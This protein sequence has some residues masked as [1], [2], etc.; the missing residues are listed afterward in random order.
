MN[1]PLIFKRMLGDSETARAILLHDWSATGL[2]PMNGWSP[3][4]RSAVRMVCRA[5]AS[6]ALLWGPEGLL[7]YNQGYREIV[8]ERHPAAL[9]ASAFSVW[10]EAESFNRDVVRRV[11]EGESVSLRDVEFLLQRDGEQRPAWFDLDYSPLLDDQGIVLGALALVVEKTRTILAVKQLEQERA[12]F[13]DLF[14]QAPTFMAL[15][16]GPQ[17]VFDRVNPGYA[18]L[19]GHRD[20]VGKTVAQAL[21]E[22]VEQGF[23]DLLDRVFQ[24]GVAF[25]G[26]A[27][28]F[29]VQSVPGGR[30]DLRYLDFVYQPIRDF[31]GAV[32]SIFVEGVD[33]TERELISAEIRR[34][35]V[36]N[37][38]ILDSAIDYAIV[39]F[40][41][42]GKVTQWNQGAFRVLGWSEQEML[43]Q[44]GSRFFTP[45]DRAADRMRTEM[46]CALESG[47][48]ND[49][50]WHLRKS[51][52]RFWAS[53]EMTPLLDEQ[54]R[55]VGFVKVL[56]D[57]TERHRA[58]KAL[59]D[60]VR[61]L[62]VAQEIGALGT[63]T[64]DLESGE[65]QGTRGFFRIFGLPGQERIDAAAIE[66]LVVPDDALVRSSAS[67]RLDQSAP[68]D[69]Q[70]RIRRADDG[71]ERWIARQAEFERDA[72]GLPVRMVGVVQDITERKAQEMAV[73]ESSAQFKTLAQALPNQVWTTSA[74]GK[75]DWIN[76]RLTDYIGADRIVG[77]TQSWLDFLHADDLANTRML[78]E[79]SVATG[80]PYETE[81]RLQR[82]DG[83]YRWHLSR[84]L[85]L[86]T[87]DGA[88][89]RWIGTSTDIHANK[90]LE[91]QTKRDRNR[92]WTLS[93]ELMLIYTFEG[94]IAA[95]N[96]SATRLLGWSE[97]DM[98]GR[99][100]SD[101]LHADDIAASA[102]EVDKLNHGIT[103]LA[104][105]NRYRGKDGAFRV[106]DWT[107]VPD[108]GMIHAIGR[109]VT[110]ERATEAAL[111]Q[112]Q[113]L[114]AIGQLTG[115]VA[116]DFNNVLAVIRTAVDM[117]RLVKLTEERRVRYVTA[118]SDAVTRA[119]KLTAQLL[120]FARR[121]ALQPVVFDVNRNI[122]QVSAMVGSL[123]GARV[124]MTV[125][126]AATP[127]FVDADPNQF[128]TAIVN[129]A[130]N[131]RDA[132]NGN[133]R[134]T[135]AVRP[136]AEI[137]AVLG[138]D[139]VA[140]RFVA[141]SVAD[142]G[143]GIS[144]DN[145]VQIFEP[146][147]TTK[148]VGH[149]TGLGLSQVFGFAK[150]SGG[151]ITV[152]S[153]P[154]AGATFTLFLPRSTQ[155][156]APDAESPLTRIARG[157]GGCVLVVEDNPE[158]A[159]SVEMTLEELG[160][161]TVVALS[162]EQALQIL[163]NDATGFA[164]VFSDVVLGG[165][166]GIE[167]GNHVR[168]LYP[169]LP[170]VLSSGYSYVLATNPDH[171]FTLLPKPYALA[172]LA[173][174]LSDAI[175]GRVAAAPAPLA[176][177]A[178]QSLAAHHNVND[179]DAELFRQAELDSLQIL[180]TGD[181]AVFD[182]ITRMAAEYCGVP[183][184]LISL[185]DADRQW[186]K[187]RVGLQAQ[188]TPREYAFCD[189]A[190]RVPNETLIVHDATA[191]VRF[192]DNPLVTG[193][194][195]IRFYAGAPLVTSNGKAIGTLC[196]IDSVARTLDAGQIEMLNLL[197]K[198]VIYLLE[199]RRSKK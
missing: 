104:F 169:A 133:G 190:I 154:G 119:T 94:K 139:A 127:C 61:R 140:G 108:G 45:E 79:R 32:T 106:F 113:K 132:M 5:P 23:V 125:D 193:D 100:L 178:E 160:Y 87:P 117:M 17:H 142:T 89:S 70:Y 199:E 166:N 88:I 111:R 1:A 63:Y 162:A 110:R 134:L 15:L 170:I 68:L 20:V 177:A 128:D 24:T 122:Q 129:L 31:N 130:V 116:H 146:F 107:A 147:F 64:V 189:H 156:S 120:A 186:F 137:P 48:G 165:M 65:L 38:Q 62:D 150:Q 109:D 2:G 187:S 145:L 9:G 6:M 81:F 66:A 26:N 103:T 10:P 50:R 153:E 148:G 164:V 82:H 181:E 182:E 115:G 77:G 76:R 75:L 151:E 143:F 21:P 98:V 172:E 179:G 96:P 58:A 198:R 92:I 11:G 59:D 95:V 42:D 27:V 163:A 105:E 39:A 184:A 188:Q 192:A 196:V 67:S 37:R 123:T 4:L 118:I 53:G 93:Q 157:N 174:T 22:A 168:R 84:A 114:E 83:Q 30:A 144:A 57:Q 85:P 194:P 73:E 158:L 138:H 152:Q 56:R 3:D 55:P 60:S 12:T 18:K 35:E 13:A 43:G 126:L 14:E 183:I 99:H 33:V 41:L 44:D 167:L 86:R 46:R 29:A 141:I 102:A 25:S 155:V 195:N 8:G 69:V 51:G 52:E 161:S 124:T 28:E 71:A 131:A 49:E 112:S 47:V 185:I 101:F 173:R 191:D 34:A 197:A 90:L 91:E 171:G 180:D 54:D 136:V 159:G 78:W 149:G 40:D 121:Q 175:A 19:V 7:I 176:Y 80:E 72:D 16:R 97:S 36:R 74:E 135:I